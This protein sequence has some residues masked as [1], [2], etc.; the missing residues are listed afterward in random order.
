MNTGSNTIRVPGIGWIDGQAFGCV[1]R[2]ERTVYG[3]QADVPA[4][5]RRPDL[6]GGPVKNIG[7]FDAVSRLTCCACALALRDAGLSVDECRKQAIGLVGANAEGSLAANRA[8]F[9]DYLQA[10]RKLG[11]GNLFIYTLP[12]SP[13]AEA[14]IHFGLQAC[15]LYVGYPANGLTAVP[16]AHGAP[17]DERTAL[18]A[19]LPELLHTAAELIA[20]GQAARILAV[21]AD[22]QE[23]MGFLLG[24][25]EAADGGTQ[26][27]VDDICACAAG[28]RGAA[29]LVLRL[30]RV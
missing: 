1:R 12:T 15:L 18:P 23:A 2:N 14:A 13:L 24:P 4:P 27:T 22:G 10:G 26:P 17:A 6:L 5:W 21:R 19:G 16:P 20:D 11:R 28:P 9:T 29:G 25:A 8:Y 30:E 3:G 7:R